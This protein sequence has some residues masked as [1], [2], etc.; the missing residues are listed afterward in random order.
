MARLTSRVTRRE[1]EPRTDVLYRKP[2]T[3]YVYFVYGMHH[4]LNVVTREEGYPA[5]VLIQ[6]VD[7]TVGPGRVTRYL[8]VDGRLNGVIAE[9]ANGLWFEDWGGRVNRSVIRQ[10]PRIGVEYAGPIWSRKLWRFKLCIKKRPQKLRPKKGAR[11]GLQ[12]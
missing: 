12:G 11:I 2:G 9:K 4:M 5:A 1:G 7:D 10:S 3:L 8:R 6:S